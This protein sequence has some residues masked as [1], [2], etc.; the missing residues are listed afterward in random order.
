[1][2]AFKLS[3]ILFSFYQKYELLDARSIKCK[4]QNIEW[5]LKHY[6][7]ILLVKKN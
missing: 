2:V 3:I 6:M 1:M 5:I 7:E 4:R